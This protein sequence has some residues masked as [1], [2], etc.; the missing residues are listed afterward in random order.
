MNFSEIINEVIDIEIDSLHQLKTQV[1]GNISDVIDTIYNSKGKLVITGVGKSGLIGK[2]ISATLSSTGTP[3]VF[4]HSTEALHGDLGLI[5]SEDVIFCIS[6]SG[7]TD[8]LLK[9]IPSLL[10]LK[11]KIIGVTGNIESTLAMNSDFVINVK[12][13]KEACPLELAPTSSST[14]TLVIGDALSVA[15]M[16][17]RK[18]KAIDFASFHPGGSLG[19]KLLCRVIDEM[20]IDNLPTNKENDSLREVINSLTKGFVG[21]TVVINDNDLIKGIITDGDLRRSLSLDEKEF[22]TLKAKDIMKSNPVCIKSE[23]MIYE[24]ENI[25]KSN[26]INS[27]LVEDKGKLIGVLTYN[28]TR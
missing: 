25:M 4:M 20:Y 28:K 9:I 17:K 26:N 27:L 3:S 15:L 22:F 8:E 21:L 19:R 2:K 7:E 18:F 1:Q 14:A 12:V 16:K 24:A 13:E 10:S 5:N 23:V 11:V 6:Y